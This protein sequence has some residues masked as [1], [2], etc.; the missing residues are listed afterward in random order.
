RRLVED[1][2]YEMCVLRARGPETLHRRG[3]PE[4]HVPCLEDPAHR[5]LAEDPLQ[6]VLPEHVAR[7]LPLRLVDQE[8]RRLLATPLRGEQ[9]GPR[10]RLEQRP[11]DLGRG[12]RSAGGLVPD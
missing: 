12:P 4:A 10:L 3:P 8:K 6:P 7:L 2:V 11:P 5:P 1:P 9:L